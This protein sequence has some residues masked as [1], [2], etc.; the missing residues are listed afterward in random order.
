MK[1]L[2]VLPIVLSAV[3]LFSCNS[4]KREVERVAQA[5]L[6]AET[7]FKI[8]E[9]RPYVAGDEMTS[10][11]NMIENFVMPNM[12][13]SVLDSL[14]PCKVKI[15][16]VDMFADTAAVVS[17]HSSNLKQESDAQILMSKIDGEWKVVAQ[18]EKVEA[19]TAKK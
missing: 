9:A 1:L 16:D 5:Y 15:T 18:G 4:E 14:V 19:P 8:D 2:R 10:A 17:F 6:D 7:N 12:E 11:M 13:K 3:V